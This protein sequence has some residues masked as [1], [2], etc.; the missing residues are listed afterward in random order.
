MHLLIIAPVYFAISIANYLAEC[1]YSP[2][3]PHEP[4][5]HS[6]DSFSTVLHS[7]ATSGLVKFNI[8]KAIVFAVVRQTA[9]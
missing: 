5:M 4:A 1:D 6:E 3:K 2:G 7:A 8:E 9:I